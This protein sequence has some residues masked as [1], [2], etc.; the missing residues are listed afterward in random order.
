MVFFFQSRFDS[1]LLSVYVE[2]TGCFTKGFDEIGLFSCRVWLDW[3]GFRTILRGLIG[4]HYDKDL[5]IKAASLGCG[6]CRRGNVSNGRW[7][8]RSH[9]GGG[10][11]GGG[12]FVIDEAKPCWC[13]VDMQPERL[14]VLLSARVGPL[15]DPY[16]VLPSLIELIRFRFGLWQ[17]KRVLTELGSRFSF[18]NPEISAS[19]LFLKIFYSSRGY[20]SK[21]ILASSAF[22]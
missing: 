5:W 11:W 7:L 21:L 8:I 17:S 9:A 20:Y 22:H 19:A 14:Y 10:G 18:Q 16:R 2:R 6:I 12:C 15:T 4:L 1:V 13:D 3:I